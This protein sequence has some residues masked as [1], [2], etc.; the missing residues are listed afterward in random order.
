MKSH[1]NLLRSHIN[2]YYF[3]RK[4]YGTVAVH[5]FRFIMSAGAMLR[6]LK[7]AAVWLISPGRRPEAGPKV[8]AY[9]KVVLLGAA[10]HPEDLPDDLRRGD[11]D[12][13]LL[14]PGIP[15]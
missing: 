15:R 8:E 5:V 13:D 2:R 12:F 7:Y 14:G 9:W 10:A 4:H 3:I 11:A 6:L 1:R